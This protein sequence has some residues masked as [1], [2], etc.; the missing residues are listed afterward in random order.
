VTVHLQ[1]S[2]APYPALLFSNSSTVRPVVVQ[3]RR[4]NGAVLVQMVIGPG[5]QMMVSPSGLGWPY[6]SPTDLTIGQLGRR[7]GYR[8]LGRFTARDRRVTTVQPRYLRWPSRSPST[9]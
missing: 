2:H 9:K 1:V 6:S 4:L 3:F 7:G 5:Q 8:L